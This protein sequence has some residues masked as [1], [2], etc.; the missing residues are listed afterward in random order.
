MCCVGQATC[1]VYCGDDRSSK[2]LAAGLIRDVGCQTHERR[3]NMKVTI[4]VML[5]SALGYGTAAVADCGA[6][7]SANSQEQSV[8]QPSEFIGTSQVEKA[9]N[10]SVSSRWSTVPAERNPLY[11]PYEDGGYNP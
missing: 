7:P 3:A 1:L 5:I 11:T 4:P 9:K 2:D 10:D 8:V 6:Q